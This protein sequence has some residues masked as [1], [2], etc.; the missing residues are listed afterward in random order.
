MQLYHGDCLEV[1]KQIPDKSVD[2]ILCDLPYEVTSQNTWDK[3][4]PLQD[5]WISYRRISKD[6]TPVV[7]FS[8][9]VFTAK[10]ILSNVSDFKY[11]LVW[12]KVLPSGFLNANKQPL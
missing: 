11:T 12:D 7:L 2:M 10:L 4:L 3:Q 8:Q 9:G 6:T 1:M 5:L